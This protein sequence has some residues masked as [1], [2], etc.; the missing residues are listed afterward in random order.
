MKN[1]LVDS[2]MQNA[3]ET[4]I[5]LNPKITSTHKIIKYYNLDV[6]EINNIGVTVNNKLVELLHKFE[7]A[8]MS[9][10]KENT[11]GSISFVE[12]AVIN[13][14]CRTVDISNNILNEV[15]KIVNYCKTVKKIMST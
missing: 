11:I 10:Y 14:L 6:K 2:L 4:Y 9:L 13:D 15:S 1:K 3:Q 5:R 8:N 7:E 12:R